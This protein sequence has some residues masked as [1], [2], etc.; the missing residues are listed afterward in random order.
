[1]KRRS[2]LQAIGLVG[3]GITTRAVATSQEPQ[4]FVE[5]YHVLYRRRWCA[6]TTMPADLRRRLDARAAINAKQ[7]DGE[8]IS[9]DYVWLPW[10]RERYEKSDALHIHGYAGVKFMVRRPVKYYRAPEADGW[11]RM[12]DARAG[13][14]G[15]P[16]KITFMDHVDLHGV[17]RRYVKAV[18]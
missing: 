8:I 6:A 11:H 7:L 5:Q 1:M 3:V 9:R 13:S 15:G 17:R 2:F 14:L 16:N 4:T 12:G 10:D 18:A